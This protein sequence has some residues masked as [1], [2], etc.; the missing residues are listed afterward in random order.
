MYYKQLQQLNNLM[1]DLEYEIF[2]KNKLQKVIFFI[3]LIIKQND[4]LTEQNKLFQNEIHEN[5][6]SIT[7][8]E[9]LFKKLNLTYKDKTC[10]TEEPWLPNDN[11]QIKYSIELIQNDMRLNLEYISKFVPEIKSLLP[12][13]NCQD[14]IDYR[15]KSRTSASSNLQKYELGNLYRIQNK[16]SSFQ[17]LDFSIF[18]PKYISIYVCIYIYINVYKYIYI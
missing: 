14:H 8:L 16:K 13:Y 2:E 5:K 18:P 6:N 4:F 11:G 3:Y 10:Q 12:A 9:Q 17:I 15:N 1:Q 7:K